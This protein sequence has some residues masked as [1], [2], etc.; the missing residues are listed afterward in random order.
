[1][2]KEKQ[3]PSGSGVKIF[4]RREEGLNKLY[5]LNPN[6]EI[7]KYWIKWE[8]TNNSSLPSGIRPPGQDKK[9]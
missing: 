6:S 4:S 5:P 2:G 1:L 8:T 7:R 9:T 3:T